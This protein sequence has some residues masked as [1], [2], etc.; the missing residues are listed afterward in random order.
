METVGL[1]E[2]FAIFNDMA[3][4][5][6]GYGDKLDQ[7]IAEAYNVAEK[8]GKVQ[9]LDEKVAGIAAEALEKKNAKVVMQVE[10]AT[11]RMNQRLEQ[12]ITLE[13]VKTR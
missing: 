5:N 8:M 12:N 13:T 7:V 9:I 4:M 3:E 2:Q 6:L 11:E 1:K 10:Q